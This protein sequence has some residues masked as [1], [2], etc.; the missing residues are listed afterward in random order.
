MK[1]TQSIILSSLL[2][3][4]SL[5][6]RDFFESPL[7]LCE[8]Q[9]QRQRTYNP[10]VA[11]IRQS[12]EPAGCTLTMI[13]RACAVT[14]GH[15]KETLDIA[16]FNLPDRETATDRP[17]ATAEDTYKVDVDSL[18][19]RNGGIS[20]DWAVVRL[21]P[22]DVTGDLPGDVQGFYSVSYEGLE[23]GDIVKIQGHGYAANP[24]LSF[25]QLGH[26]GEVVS[27]QNGRIDH[28]VDTTG[29]SSGSSIRR[30]SDDAI[31]GVHTHGGCYPRMMPSE[32]SGGSAALKSFFDFFVF[33]NANAG[34]SLAD[35]PEFQQA[36]E[37]CLAYEQT[38]Y[39]DTQ[40]Q[41]TQEL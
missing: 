31:V 38:M 17:V 12:D 34:T 7:S 10:K 25:S 18:V 27:A 15:C 26:Q 39:L 35:N 19:Y 41:Q 24:I 6:A 2:L 40:Q 32:A 30:E 13:G 33:V 36:I 1:L 16:E 20:R 29:G 8:Q 9:D 23:K 4:P 21:L 14:A 28:R 3:A 5:Y 11:R 37:D 22:N